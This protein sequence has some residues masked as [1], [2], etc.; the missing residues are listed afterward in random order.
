[1]DLRRMRFN[2]FVSDLNDAT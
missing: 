2:S 1:L